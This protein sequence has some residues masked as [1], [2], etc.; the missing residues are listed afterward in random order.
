MTEPSRYAVFLRGINV[1][2][3][4]IR[5]A[6]LKDCLAH[7]PFEGV[8]TLL[9][10]GNVVLDSD[11][12]PDAVKQACEDALRTRFGYDA[13]VIVT[14]PGDLA[15]VIAA[16]PYPPDDPAV[17]SYVTLA[18]DPASLDSLLAEADAQG[19]TGVVRLSPHTIAWPAPVGSSTD[20]PFSKL[21][22]K[23]RYKAS[24]TTR[25]LRTLLKVQAALA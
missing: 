21:T 7:G 9:A 20:V 1:G 24:T 22:A 15:H 12:G 19:I 18:S 4:N 23:A 10:T 5:M 6:D 8:K 17:H 14:T 11:A 25:N 13:W 2:G 3:I 16:V